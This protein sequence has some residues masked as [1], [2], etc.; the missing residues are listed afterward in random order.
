MSKEAWIEARER[1]IMER[2]D[3]FE[4]KT[5]RYATDEDIERIEEELQEQDIIDNISAASDWIYEMTK[6]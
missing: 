1:V 2:I 3:E 4:K 6:P 5:G